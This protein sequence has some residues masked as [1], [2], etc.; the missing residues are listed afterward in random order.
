MDKYTLNNASFAI[1][2]TREDYFNNVTQMIDK[3][4]Y[5]IYDTRDNSDNFVKGETKHD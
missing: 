4:I 3:M 1:K 5:T 2:L